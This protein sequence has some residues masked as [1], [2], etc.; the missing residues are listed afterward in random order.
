MIWNNGVQQQLVNQRHVYIGDI[1]AASNAAAAAAAAAGDTDAAGR[2]TVSAKET[3]AMTATHNAAAAA[4]CAALTVTA[5]LT[6]NAAVAAASDTAATVAAVQATSQGATPACDSNEG[7]VPDTV[8]RP[9]VGKSGRIRLL[10]LSLSV[11]W[12]RLAV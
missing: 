5:A 12:E 1:I 2:E 6:I 10:I 4:A 8:P 7:L 11:M 3:A 9:P